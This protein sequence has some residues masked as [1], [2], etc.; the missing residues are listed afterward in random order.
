MYT[1]D[2][3][4][5]K[6]IQIEQ[7]GHDLYLMISENTNVENKLKIMAKI[8]A[9]EETKHMLAYEGFKKNQSPYDNIEIDFTTYDKATELIY[10]FSKIKTKNYI[11]DVTELFKSALIFEKENLSLV[12]I[13]SGLFVKSYKDL[14]SR[15]YLIFSEIIKE[16]QMHVDLMEDILKRNFIN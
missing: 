11:S 5:D 7:E 14:E 10:E 3:L 16:E 9:V 13:L 8:L 12:L 6:L 1:I 2:N 4:I 15:N